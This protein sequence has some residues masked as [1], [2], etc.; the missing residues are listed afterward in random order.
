MKRFRKTNHAALDISSVTP[1]LAIG[2]APKS[3][4]AIRQMR[5]FAISHV[6]DL[7]A[8]RKKTDH[9]LCVRD[10]HVRWV[11]FYDDW[12]PKPI[13]VFRQI[14]DAIKHTGNE[15][16][17]FICCGA[18]EHRAPLGGVVALLIDGYTIDHAIELIQ[19]A[20]PVAEILPI[21]RSSLMEF[22]EEANGVF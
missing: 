6:L 9:L 7:R 10:L 13:A 15:G 19:R 4:A 12:R 2:A 21:Y 22:V 16:K 17:L 20:R 3:L 8:E 5:N 11:P 1:K 18:G 14:A